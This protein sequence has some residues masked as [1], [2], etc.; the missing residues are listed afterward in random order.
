MSDPTT[1]GPIFQSAQRALSEAL[2]EVPAGRR[3]AIVVVAHENDVEAAVYFRGGEHWEFG[4]SVKAAQDQKP[5][6]QVAVRFTW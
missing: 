3:G 2:A 6:G 5:S 4:G 1:P